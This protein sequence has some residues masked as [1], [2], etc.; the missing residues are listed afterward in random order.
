MSIKVIL[1]H[2]EIEFDQKIE[3][4]EYLNNNSINFEEMLSYLFNRY[5]Y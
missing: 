4:I 2:G 1:V 5:K 3:L